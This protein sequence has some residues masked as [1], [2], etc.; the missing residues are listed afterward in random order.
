[1]AFEMKYKGFPKETKYLDDKK[2][3]DKPEP[4]TNFDPRIETEAEVK[5]ANA[6][7]DANH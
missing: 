6:L 3:K 4:K 7:E 1:M 2:N 5:K